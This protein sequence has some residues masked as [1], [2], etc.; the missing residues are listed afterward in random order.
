V[1]VVDTTVAVDHL[2]GLAS[3]TRLL[4]DLG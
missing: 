1:K 2:R 3:A 4:T